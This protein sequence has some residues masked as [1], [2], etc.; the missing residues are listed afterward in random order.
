MNIDKTITTL[1]T[2]IV[3]VTSQ[4]VKYWTQSIGALDREKHSTNDTLIFHCLEND[5]VPVT[6][7]IVA[8]LEA[9]PV[10]T[11]TEKNCLEK[12]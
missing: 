4:P 2:E 12:R 3:T 7:E 1:I 9:M 11:Y 10:S 5:V 8:A 6:I